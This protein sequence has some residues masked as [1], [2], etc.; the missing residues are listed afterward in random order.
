MKK[1]TILVF[2]YYSNMTGVCQAEWVDDRIN[3]F[4]N[5]GYNILLISSICSF[6]NPNIRHIRVPSFTPNGFIFEQ[7]QIKKKGIQFSSRTKSFFKIYY[8]ISRCISAILDKLYLKSGEG[9]WGWFFSSFIASFY[10]IK[11]FKQID[12]IYTTGGPPSAHFS[13]IVLSKLIRIKNITELQDPLTGKDIGRNRFSKLAFTYVEKIL[14]KF[15][16]KTIFCTENAMIVAKEKYKMLKH[17]IDFVY[18]GSNPLNEKSHLNKNNLINFT[19]LGS[20]Y[21]TRNFDNLMSSIKHISQ[22][23]YDF[24]NL[25]EIN[26]YGNMDNDIKERIILNGSNYIKM[27][28]L[29][30]R[31]IAISC[32]N[33]SDVLI[34]VQNTDDRSIV[35]IPF[36]TYD[37][38][39]SGKI[40]FGIIYKN[41]ELREMLENHGHISCQADNIEDISNKLEYII[42]NHLEISK[43]IKKSNITPSQAVHKMIQILQS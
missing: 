23:K 30:S 34:L 12:Y 28:G 20:L 31:E 19:Y 3:A 2:S 21:Q 16:T 6:K 25:F 26:I 10:F 13:G 27:H 33:K 24:T 18:P 38:L 7:D 1:K 36:K 32:A 17:K 22:T 5:N 42:D 43:N 14:I 35:T 8:Y 40:I 15:S 4:I 29:V 39:N 41:D 11:D 37:Y 9:R